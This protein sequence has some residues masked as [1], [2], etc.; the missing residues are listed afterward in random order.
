MPARAM[1]AAFQAGLVLTSSA[2][3]D[4]FEQV[5]RRP[6]FN[7]HRDL[8]IRLSYLESLLD[9]LTPITVIDLVEDCRDPNDN[10]FLALALNGKADVIVT[11]DDHLLCLHPWRGIAILSPADYLAQMV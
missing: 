6:K 1:G 11:G 7:R 10:M 5:L 9:L 8:D 2:V 4:E 3:I